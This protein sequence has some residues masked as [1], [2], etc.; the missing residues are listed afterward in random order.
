MTT[1]VRPLLKRACLVVAGLFAA[2][3]AWSAEPA[4]GSDAHA[5]EIVQ[6]MAATL[7]AQ[8]AF[9]FTATTAYDSRQEDGTKVEFGDTRKIVVRRPDKLRV[10]VVRTDGRRSSVQYDGKVLTAYSADANVYAQSEKAGTVDDAIVHFLS[11]LKMKL[12]LAALLSSRAAE[13]LGR[14]L[15]S[16]EYVEKSNACAVPCHHVLAGTETTDLQAW[17]SEGAV[18]VLLKVVIT[19][20]DEP[21]EPQ[22]RA[23]LSD[24]NFAPK[25]DDAAFTFVPPPSATGI[26]FAASAVAARSGD[27]SGDQP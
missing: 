15:L 23:V 14:R 1:L 24:W 6:K 8:D 19:Y 4:P 13:D 3:P 18:P 17:I 26:P 27:G 22:F 10:D 21:G 12:P 5:R 16:V 11:T 7:A 25:I 20:H 2:A 9:S